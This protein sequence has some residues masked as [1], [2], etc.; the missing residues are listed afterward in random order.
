MEIKTFGRPFNDLERLEM[1]KQRMRRAGIGGALAVV[2]ASTVT[3]IIVLT[4]KG[5]RSAA[6]AL[7]SNKKEMVKAIKETPLAP[8][9]PAIR[10][11]VEVARRA[12][13]VVSDNL[14]MIVIPLLLLYFLD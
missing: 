9:A 2:L 5:G 11:S 8:L 3:A 1:F 13:E 14:W 12:T 7:A 6:G 4:R 10:K